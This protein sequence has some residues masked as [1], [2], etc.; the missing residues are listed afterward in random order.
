[1]ILLLIVHIYEVTNLPNHFKRSSKDILPLNSIHEPIEH[2]S[3][4]SNRKKKGSLS[5][6][7]QHPIYISNLHVIPLSNVQHLHDN[8]SQNNNKVLTFH[9][10]VPVHDLTVIPLHRV[11]EQMISY[12]LNNDEENRYRNPLGGY[13]IGWQFGGHGAGHGFHYSYG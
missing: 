5:L 2:N 13:G 7:I 12:R 1:M 6:Q 8:L 9:N 10:L 11:S 4:P 3:I